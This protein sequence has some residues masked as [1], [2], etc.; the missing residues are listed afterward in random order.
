MQISITMGSF[1]STNEVCDFLNVF[2]NARRN[3]PPEEKLLQVLNVH[4][5][6]CKSKFLETVKGF[7]KINVLYNTFIN[8]IF[9][10]NRSSRG[11]IWLKYLFFFSRSDFF[12]EIS[13]THQIFQE[14]VIRIT[15]IL[16]Y[17]SWNFPGE[18]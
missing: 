9:Y 7:R 16:H 1:R 2:I 11:A 8:L 12:K 17:I 5:F 6:I 4:S 3:I 14:D 13:R 15:S 18:A 10:R